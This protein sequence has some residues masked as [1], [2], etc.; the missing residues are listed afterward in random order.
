MAQTISSTAAAQ[1][2]AAGN[3]A[4][5]LDGADLISGSTHFIQ[6]KLDF[7]GNAADT[8]TVIIGY[9]PAGVTV[10]PGAIQI[11][12]LNIGASAAATFTLGISDTGTELSGTDTAIGAAGIASNL[13]SLIPSLKTTARV[14]I[15]VLLSAAMTAATEVI[16]NIPC[17]KAE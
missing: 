8:D 9:I 15:V 6:A 1:N 12:C 17:V 10:I 2:L 11:Q 16:F 13:I 3:S 5:F 7:E 4:K 14:P